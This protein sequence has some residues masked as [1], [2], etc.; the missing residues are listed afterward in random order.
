MTPDTT[1]ALTGFMTAGKST[2]GPQLAMRLGLDFVDLDALLEE[3]E[4][5]SIADLFARDGEEAFRLLEAGI[6]RSALAGPPRVLSTGGG[7]VMRDE[8]RRRLARRA[9]VVWLDLRFETVLARLRAGPERVRP[10]AAGLDAD[11]LRELHRLRRPLYA[12]C[13]HLRVDAD[14]DAP[15]R[16]ARRIA[17]HLQRVEA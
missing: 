16:L 12:S 8:N 15:G 5:A 7:V 3:Q 13:A 11:G 10:V 2:I 14:R 4:D 17:L 9:H 1:V 6:L